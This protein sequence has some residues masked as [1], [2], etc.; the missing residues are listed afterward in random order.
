M[1]LVVARHSLQC[2]R[3]VRLPWLSLPQPQSPS[4]IT[5]IP[6]DNNQPPHCFAQLHPFT[7]VRPHA[8]FQSLACPATIFCPQISSPSSFI[9]L[10]S[11]SQA[12]SPPLCL[13]LHAHIS[14]QVLRQ[15]RLHRRR[16]LHLTKHLASFLSITFPSRLPCFLLRS[17]GLAAAPNLPFPST[18]SPTEPFSHQLNVHHLPQ[19]ANLPST[20]LQ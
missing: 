15:R 2:N 19:N 9:P 12:S 1:H 8:P 10:P 20:H 11:H 6:K 7:L 3:D 16:G 5:T 13:Y 18:P 4:V 14:A 17:F